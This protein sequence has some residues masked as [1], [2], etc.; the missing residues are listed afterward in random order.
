MNAIVLLLSAAILSPIHEVAPVPCDTEEMAIEVARSFRPPETSRWVTKLGKA[1]EGKQARSERFRRPWSWRLRKT[2]IRFEAVAAD[3]KVTVNGRATGE[4][5]GAHG[6]VEFDITDALKWFGE[7]VVEIRTGD[8]LG[9][10][11]TVFRR[12]LLVSTSRKS[13]K[14]LKAE[15]TINADYSAAAFRILDDKGVE[16]K[17]RDVPSPQFWSDEMP[18]ICM[19]PIETKYGWWKFGGIEYRALMFGLVRSEIRD[20]ELFLNGKKMNL[21]VAKKGEYTPGAKGRSTSASGLAQDIYSLKYMNFNAVLARDMP[22]ICQFYDFCDRDGLMVLAG[23]DDDVPPGHAC[24][25]PLD[26][27]KFES[28][29]VPRGKKLVEDL[30]NAQ[31]QVKISRIRRGAVKIDNGMNFLDLEKFDGWVCVDSNGKDAITGEEPEVKKIS[32]PPGGTVRLDL[33]AYAKGGF[34]LQLLRDEDVVVSKT[35]GAAASK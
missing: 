25:I 24:V 19:T 28:V 33:S 22:K 16:L 35:F 11:Q 7:N 4:S 34:T 2:A 20:G 6:V 27:L 1:W 14:L 10:N 29:E 5:K 32:C 31:S 26:G 18:T 12:V 23:R 13:P 15:T 3:F 17:R 21:R 8:P 30:R 9:G